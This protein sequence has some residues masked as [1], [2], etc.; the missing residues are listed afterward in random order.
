M[1]HKIEIGDV[2]VSCKPVASMP[3]AHYIRIRVVGEPITTFGRYGYG[4]VDVVTIAADGREVRRRALEASQ[5]HATA[6]TRDG[7]LRRT[8]YV[9]EAS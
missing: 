8:G 2:Y 6:T 3:D 5:L 9:L 1:I 4:K 7:R